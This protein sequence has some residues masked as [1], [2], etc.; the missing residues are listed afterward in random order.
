MITAPALRLDRGP[1]RARLLEAAKRLRPRLLL[2][3]A[4]G[5]G[6]RGSSDIRAFGGSDPNLRRAREYLVLC[7]E[8][9][10]ASTSAPVDLAMDAV[11]AETT[12]LEVVAELQDGN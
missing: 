5:Q 4:A 1:D 3:V 9:W 6:L 11:K 2:L 10:T 12:R 7:S 8:H